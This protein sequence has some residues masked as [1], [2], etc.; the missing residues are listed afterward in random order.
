MKLKIVVGTKDNHNE[1][2]IWTVKE[3]D[4][5]LEAEIYYNQCLEFDIKNK[6]WSDTYIELNQYETE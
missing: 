1:K 2:P 4:N 5:L 3:F 6:G